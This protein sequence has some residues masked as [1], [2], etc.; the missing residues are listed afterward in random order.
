[1]PKI[2]VIVGSFR[3]ESINQR[4]ANALA[5]LA[6]A[7]HDV[8][9]VR[10]DDLPLFNQDLESNLPAPVVR[11]KSEIESADA[12]LVVTPEYNRSLPAPLKKA[13]D[14]GSRPS[15][16]NSFVGK[17]SAIIGTTMGAVGTAAV[18]QH[19]RAV[20]IQLNTALMGPPEGYIVYKQG[21]VDDDGNVTVESTQKFLQTWVDAFSA[22]IER[23]KKK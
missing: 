23:V 7:K 1:M 22:W 9:F 6:K 11:L 10:I 19:L 20:M 13:L 16:K 3:R 17:P 8:H 14:W 15:G 4:L 18:Q 5:K 2:A 21:L 12:I